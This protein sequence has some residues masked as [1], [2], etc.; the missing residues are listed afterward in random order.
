MDK[1]ERMKRPKLQ[2][3]RP[4]RNWSASFGL[5]A[6]PAAATDNRKRAEVPAEDVVARAVE[7]GYRV[8]DEYIRQGQRVAQRLSEP[9][10][11][12]TVLGDMQDMSSRMAQFAAEWAG[13]WVDFAQ[14]LA[15][16]TGVTPPGRWGSVAPTASPPP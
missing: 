5:G 7:L 8:V 13:L 4:I 11:A 15:T 9:S 12:G 6:M 14:R 3:D 2:R 10:R 1:H 16:G